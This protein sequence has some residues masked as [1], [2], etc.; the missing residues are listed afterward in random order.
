MNKY[1]IISD[2]FGTACCDSA[3]EAWQA[4]G[5]WCDVMGVK[6]AETNARC[7][8]AEDYEEVELLLYGS[9]GYDGYGNIKEHKE[10]ADTCVD[11]LG[12]SCKNKKLKS[13]LTQHKGVNNYVQK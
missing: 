2:A 4:F 3:A 7:I 1:R 8:Y 10:S 11:T 5:Q 6:K 13:H 9:P 12:N